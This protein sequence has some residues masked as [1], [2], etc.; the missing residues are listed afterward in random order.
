MADFERRVSQVFVPLNI[1]IDFHVTRH[2]RVAIRWSFPQR[3][4]HYQRQDGA[5]AELFFSPEE[6]K[7]FDMLVLSFARAMH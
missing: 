1:Q 5:N 2:N 7:A 3:V 4:A 6:N